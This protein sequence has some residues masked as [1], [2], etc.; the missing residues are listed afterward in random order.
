MNQEGPSQLREVLIAFS[1]PIPM[2]DSNE[3]KVLVILK[4]MR[5]HSGSF[6]DRLIIESDSSDVLMGFSFS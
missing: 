2:K 5:T 4:A 6:Q 3:S 1:K